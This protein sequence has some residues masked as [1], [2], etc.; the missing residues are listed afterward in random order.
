MIMKWVNF[1]MHVAFLNLCLSCPLYV[2]IH[3]CYLYTHYPRVVFFSY[4]VLYGD[5]NI[6]ICVLIAC[7]LKQCE[8]ASSCRLQTLTDQSNIHILIVKIGMWRQ[9]RVQ[10]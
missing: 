6:Y 9:K 5:L 8:I 7:K 10:A 1:H 3:A 2:E 4:Q